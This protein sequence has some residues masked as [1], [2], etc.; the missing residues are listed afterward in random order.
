M[1]ILIHKYNLG[2]GIKAEYAFNFTITYGRMFINIPLPTRPFIVNNDE[3]I[4]SPSF[5][6]RSGRKSI[7][8]DYHKSFP[9]HCKD[10]NGIE[11]EFDSKTLMY[12][13]VRNYGLTKGYFVVRLDEES[14]SGIEIYRLEDGKEIPCSMERTTNG[15]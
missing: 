8:V 15:R 2:K 3:P 13:T 9:E 11:L 4:F 10:E 7:R 5:F 6:F 14:E 12:I 1:L